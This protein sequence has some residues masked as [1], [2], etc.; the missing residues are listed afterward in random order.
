MKKNNG[1][2][3]KN[4]INE[5]VEYHFEKIIT[6]TTSNRAVT[7]CSTDEYVDRTIDD[8]ELCS[9]GAN[10]KIKGIDNLDGASRQSR[11]ARFYVKMY[12]KYKYQIEVK[13]D[14]IQIFA[15]LF[16]EGANQLD[17]LESL[18]ELLADDKLYNT[19]MKYIRDYI[20]NHIMIEVN[21]YSKTISLARDENGKEIRK[22]I[23]LD[24]A[25]N[26]IHTIVNNDDEQS[27]LINF[28]GD[29]NKLWTYGD[30]A[31]YNH[32]L[33]WFDENKERLLTE[34]Q[35]QKYEAL[36]DIY[37][38]KTDNSKETQ[39]NRR[40][41]YD[42]SNLN[43]QDIKAFKRIVKNRVVKKYQE[44]FGTENKYGFN[45]NN[46][47]KMR[48]V[49]E[50]YVEMCNASDM[51]DDATHRQIE[52]SKY[53]AQHYE[54]EAFEIVITKGLS[55]DEKKNIVRCCKSK[56]LLSHRI[57]RLIRQNIEAELAKEVREVVPA[58]QEWEGYNE[59]T[60]NDVRHVKERYLNLHSD[61]SLK[62]DTSRHELE[63]EEMLQQKDKYYEF[64]A[65]SKSSECKT[66]CLKCYE[67]GAYVEKHTFFFDELK[68]NG[69]K[70]CI[71]LC[72]K[73]DAE[74]LKNYVV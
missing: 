65:E 1:I 23:T 14:F 47:N 55:L 56:E 32:F 24:G 22:T 53:V 70:K 51:F 62:V 20:E 11:L 25:D 46:R 66:Y 30:K 34:K 74:E 17:Q 37:V 40:A 12:N 5:L 57:I 67:E 7:N 52:L 43:K 6:M 42:M 18:D 4:N 13:S 71:K 41:M 26:S 31:H 39:A 15:M 10:L 60:F 33:Q 28:L 58:K 2:D 38:A 29:E 63:H 68:A 72:E 44:E 54:T 19:R 73:C 27:E 21:P 3:F 50:Q 36:K 69:N 35:L 59:Y 45:T 48:E 16:V 64:V 8:T 9:I 49:F 61:G